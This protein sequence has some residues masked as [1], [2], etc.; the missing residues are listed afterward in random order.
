MKLMDLV[1]AYSAALDMGAVVWPY[2]LALALVRIKRAVAGDFEFFFEKEQELA[3]KYAALDDDGNLRMLSPTRFTLRDP[4]LR[5]EYE[6]ARSELCNTE[7][8]AVVTRVRVNAPAEI[9][10]EWLDALDPFI[11]FVTD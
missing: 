1:K 10:P 11:E 4:S 8:G 9:K 3:L 6:A 5:V 2:D 7:T